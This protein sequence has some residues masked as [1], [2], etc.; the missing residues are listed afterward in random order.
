MSKPI[1]PPKYLIFIAIPI[2][3]LI[4]WFIYA[5]L[6]KTRLDLSQFDL[7]RGEQIYNNA[8]IACHLAGM[9]GAPK[10]GNRKEWAPRVA[11]GMDSLFNNTLQGLNAMPPKGGEPSLSEAEVKAAVAFM[12]SKFY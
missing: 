8:C 12:L 10:I 1:L 5:T 7:Q 4:G 3:L 6:F 11:Q 9:F 2:I